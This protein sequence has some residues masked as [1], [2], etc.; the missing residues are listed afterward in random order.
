MKKGINKKI[1]TIVALIALVAVMAVCLSACNKQEDF[2]KRLKDKGYMVVTMSAEQLSAIAGDDVGFIEW[3]I[4]AMKS[5]SIL[6]GDYVMVVKFKKSDD[7]KKCEENI[8][9]DLEDGFKVIRKG[10]LVISGAE[11]AVKDAQ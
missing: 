3:A 11:E 8:K 10:N 1:L 9:T 6:E 4:M 7:A 2:E 5:G